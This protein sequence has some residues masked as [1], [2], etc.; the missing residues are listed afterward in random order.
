MKRTIYLASVGSSSK[1]MKVAIKEM[2]KRD[3][4]IIDINEI[5]PNQ[6]SPAKELAKNV[7]TTS[8]SLGI[9]MCGNGFG[10]SKEASI[11]EE[12]TVI[13]CVNVS[14]VRSGKR[15]NNANILADRKSVV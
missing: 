12:I 2:L 8:N 7:L 3:H 10:V 5:D 15:V 13:N 1:N 14:Q 6:L 9:V 11:S 4:I